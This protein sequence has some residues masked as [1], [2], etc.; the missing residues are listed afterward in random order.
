MSAPRAA[1]YRNMR[2][3]QQRLGLGSHRTRGRYRSTALRPGA[4]HLTRLGPRRCLVSVIERIERGVLVPPIESPYE[5]PIRK[6][7]VLRQARPMEVAA[8]HVPLNGALG[9]VLAVVAIAGDHRAERLGARSEIG[10]TRMVFEAHQLAI[11]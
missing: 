6:P 11:R 8:D 1:A 5:E 3:S 7:R 2:R 9:L 4:G 10:P